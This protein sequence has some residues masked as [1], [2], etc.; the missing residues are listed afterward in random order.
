MPKAL[1]IENR[2]SK[3]EFPYLLSN[4]DNEGKVFD[5]LP[6]LSYYNI[7]CMTPKRSREVETWHALNRRVTFNYD[8]EIISY[9][10]QDVEC[11]QKC[12]LSFRELFLSITTDKDLAPKGICPFYK[13]FTLPGAC[14]RVFRQL[15]LKHN[16][17]GLF[18][19]EEIKRKTRVHSL[20]AYQWL[21]YLNTVNDYPQPIQHARNSGE[22]IVLGRP[23]DGYRESGEEKYVY[24]FYGCFFH[25]HIDHISRS[26][27]HPYKKCKMGVVYD[28]T[29]ERLSS[30]RNSGYHVVTMW[31][32]EFENILKT[33]DGV[34]Q[35][36]D[37]FN[38]TPPLNPRD[39]LFGGRTNAVKLYYE[40]N[41]DESIRYYDIK[42]YIYIHSF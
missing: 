29:M 8:K 15:F 33:D 37:S 19:D 28:D 34:R 17:L 7:D 22:A 27:S 32:C 36:V 20:K 16:T 5:C 6:P 40:V 30:L 41:E 4:F 9:C 39:G 21:K 31:E 3:G 38:I 2:C 26:T 1:G 12:I 24:E 25:G 42:V 10:E 11:L 18:H 14:N 13:S 23:V 35:V